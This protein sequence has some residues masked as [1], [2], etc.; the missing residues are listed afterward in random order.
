[1]THHPSMLSFTRNF[2]HLSFMQFSK[3]CDCFIHTFWKRCE[4]LS[5]E[6][7][8]SFF[9]FFTL[10][11]LF[12]VTPFFIPSSSNTQ[13]SNWEN[14]CFCKYPHNLNYFMTESLSYRNQSIDL[15]SKLMNCFLN[16]KELCHVKEKVDFVI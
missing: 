1:M 8:N 10:F 13:M 4:F 11:L 15:L 3:R 2:Q 6:C 14:Y 12:F 7:E 16:D 5:K 9:F